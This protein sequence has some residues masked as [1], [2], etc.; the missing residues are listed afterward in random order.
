[1]TTCTMVFS[2]L[3]LALKF[4]EGAESRAPMAVSIFSRR[5]GNSMGF[6]S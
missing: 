1:M 3:P 4:E 5:R 6:V 2:M